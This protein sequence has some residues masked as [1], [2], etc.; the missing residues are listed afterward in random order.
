MLDAVLVHSFESLVNEK[1]AKVVLVAALV[2]GFDI[3][4]L[5][6]KDQSCFQSLFCEKEAKIQLGV[7]VVHTFESLVYK[8]E[9]K[10]KLPV[11]GFVLNTLLFGHWVLIAEIYEK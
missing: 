4:Y 8:K 2:Q 6:K 10:L 11:R 7:A 5:W 9:A 3:F 1:Q